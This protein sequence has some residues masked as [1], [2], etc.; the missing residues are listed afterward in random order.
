MAFTR[1][2]PT[3]RM[4][5]SSGCCWQRGIKTELMQILR[6]HRAVPGPTI[7]KR[8]NCSCLALSLFKNLL[9]PNALQPWPLL[10]ICVQLSRTGLLI[11]LYS[12]STSV[13]RSTEPVCKWSRS[14]E[15]E[16][17]SW[18][19]LVLIVSII[20]LPQAFIR[21]S[22]WGTILN[23]FSVYPQII[24][25]VAHWLVSGCKI[26]K[27]LDNIVNVA[28]QHIFAQGPWKSSGRGFTRTNLRI[29]FEIYHLM[30]EKVARTCIYS[31]I[32]YS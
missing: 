2:G 18:C 15:K 30:E 28:Q 21:D 11:R 13:Q 8:F 20:S 14:P 29:K 10:D 23:L 17:A 4:P 3:T 25:V 27:L 12:A 16:E 24:S 26:M 19:L 5:P 6:F 31:H 22:E 9:S 7:Y 32:W 1:T